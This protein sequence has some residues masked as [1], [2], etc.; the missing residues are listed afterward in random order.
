[1]KLKEILVAAGIVLSAATLV[2][3]QSK[4][5]RSSAKSE[6]AKTDEAKKEEE[7]KSLEEVVKK[8]QKFYGLFTIY[9]DTT[10]GKVYMQINGDQLNKEYIHFS[11][12][13]DGPVDIFSMRGAYSD[14][15]IFSITRYF[16]KIQITRENTSYYFDPE[17]SLSRA[18]DANINRPVI[19]LEK[20]V[21]VN[22]EKNQFLIE[23]EK[24]FLNET[25]EQV[26]PS[27]SPNEKPGQ[28]FKLGALSKEK[29]KVLNVRNYPL[30]TAVQVELVFEESYPQHYGSVDITD[31]RFVSVKIH[32]S[33]IAVPENDY[34]PRFDDPRIGYFTDQV[35]DMTSTRPAPY[36]DLVH[37]WNLKKKD[38]NAAVS[39]PVEPI[40]WW[41]ENTTPVEL[42]PYVR[43]GVLQWN[44]AFEKAGFKNAIVVRE[45]PDDAQWDAGDIRYNV[46][47]WTSSPRPPFGG[48]GPS[49]VNPRTGQI[50]GADVMLEYVFVT[51]RMREGQLFETAGAEHFLQT[52]QNE[53]HV[54]C[55]LGSHLQRSMMAGR[56]LVRTLGRGLAEEEKLL[57]QA[58]YMLTLHEVGHTL[59]LNHNMKASNLRDPVTIHDEKLCSEEGLTGSVMDYSNINISLNP[60][61]QGLYYDVVPGP[62]DVWAIQYGYSEFAPQEEEQKL[63]ELCAHSAEHALMFG[64]DADDMR[65]PGRGIDP[66]VMIDDMSSDPVVY[67]TERIQLVNKAL[68]K[69]HDKFAK[70]GESYQGLRDAFLI[71]T[72]EVWISLRVISRQVGGVYVDRSVVGQPGAGKPY[73]PV[74]YEKQ[75]Q[76]MAVLSKYAFSPEALHFPSDLYN[77]LQQQRRGFNHF[78]VNEDPRLHDRILYMHRDVLN[79]LLHQNTLQRIVDSELYGNKYTLAEVMTDLTNAIFKDDLG[80]SV[81]S[82]RQNLQ[83]EYVQRLA[84]IVK[85]VSSYTHVAKAQA[86]YELSS[87]KKMTAK[88][89]SPDTSTKAHRD[90]VKYLIDN[91]LDVD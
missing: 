87:I 91:A 34:R 38:K 59:G 14:G 90:Y 45:Q 7:I 19:F 86:F 75:K 12:V 44:R 21:A 76:A 2:F 67:S 85:S 39:E 56:Q 17:N 65:S 89:S 52:Y 77:M 70:P 36:R 31:A 37:R 51:N 49:F 79:H 72:S 55:M 15:K 23:C 47:R 50:L 33:L 64:N 84:E 1:M 88:V 69:L 78:S 4:P 73:E 41:I 60:E 68:P 43:E 28:S 13:I 10:N 74:S 83:I 11:Q 40:V 58:I 63:R 25:F 27:P 48:Y 6:P 82:V 80:K 26:K 62:Y 57:K 54:R 8:S 53:D 16:D 30:N 9:R 66:R 22:K 42:R 81:S 24:L 20:I 18:K 3:S 35:T 46:L 29:S 61:K 5:S 71:L 32:N